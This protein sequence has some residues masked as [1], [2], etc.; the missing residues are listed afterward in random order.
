MVFSAWLNKSIVAFCYGRF[1]CIFAFSLRT[2][3]YMW[4]TT[5]WLRTNETLTVGIRIY[6][7]E[8]RDKIMY[9]SMV[10]KN[11]INA[12]YLTNTQFKA[13]GCIIHSVTFERPLSGEKV[14]SAWEQTRDVY[15]KSY[16]SL[17]IDFTLQTNETCFQKNVKQP[18][19]K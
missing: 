1:C 17:K 12:R 6:K 10:A 18:F 2:K 9:F 15:C 13:E 3:H 19:V 7:P 14:W 4:L 5:R 16:E 11:L 8:F